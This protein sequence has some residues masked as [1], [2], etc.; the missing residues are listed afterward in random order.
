MIK[1]R[2][3]LRNTP[4]AIRIAG[5]GPLDH[6]HIDTQLPRRRKLGVGGCSAAVFGHNDLYFVL[7]QQRQLVIQSEWSSIQDGVQVRQ[8]ERRF[9]RFDATDQIGVLRRF[10]QRRQL[11]PAEGDKDAPACR[12]ERPDSLSNG[13]IRRPAIAGL[14]LPGRPANG[15]SH[16]TGPCRGDPGIFADPGGERM[17]CVDNHVYCFFPKIPLKPF[18]AAK[19]TAANRDSMRYGIAGTA[20]KRHRRIEPAV[21]RNPLGQQSRFGG[22]A[23]DQNA[24]GHHAF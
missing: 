23:K 16:H 3:C 6:G 2:Q 1:R 15:N 17:R 14:F 21:T 20:G 9:N 10:G 4:D 24:E 11:L 19:S 12:S 18:G 7:G 13:P 5:V 22:A 8:V